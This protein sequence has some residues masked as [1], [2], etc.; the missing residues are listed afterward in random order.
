MIAAWLA[1]FL[2]YE[3]LAQTQGLGF[4]TDVLARLNPPE[5]SIGASLPSFAVSLA[6]GAA[7]SLAARRSGAL[8]TAPRG[9]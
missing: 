8:A 2:V 9:T 3:W 4:W 5:S 6:L 1:G 7:V